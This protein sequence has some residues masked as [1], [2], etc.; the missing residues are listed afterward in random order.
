M[1][2]YIAGV[3]PGTLIVSYK[4]E[5]DKRV[6]VIVDG[7]RAID[8]SIE[9]QFDPNMQTRPPDFNDLVIYVGKKAP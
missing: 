9:K 5:G 6:P 1:G 8:Y 3:N 2:T 4:T 7:F